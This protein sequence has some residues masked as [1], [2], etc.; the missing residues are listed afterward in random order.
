MY[1]GYFAFPHIGFATEARVRVFL[2]SS[3][4]GGLPSNETTVAE[5]LKGSGYA[6]ALIG[7]SVPHYLF[8]LLSNIF[9]YFKVTLPRVMIEQGILGEEKTWRGKIVHH[10]ERCCN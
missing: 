4:R 8:S 7:K 10:W 3:S 2:F 5:L 9:G 6:T 1:V